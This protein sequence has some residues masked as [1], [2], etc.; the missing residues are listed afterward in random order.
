[1]TSTIEATLAILCGVAVFIMGNIV[2]ARNYKG[3]SNRLFFALCISVAFWGVADYIYFQADSYTVMLIATR[4]LLL[5]IFTLA[6]GLHF[7]LVFAEKT[8]LIRSRLMLLLVYGPPA[9]FTLINIPTSALSGFPIID[10]VSGNWTSDT[11][12]SF[13]Y[14]LYLFWALTVSISII[15]ISL[16]YYYA[17]KIPEQRRGAKYVVFGLSLSIIVSYI[18]ETVLPHLRFPFPPLSMEAFAVTCAIVGLGMWRSR[19]FALNTVTAAESILEAMSDTLLLVGSDKRINLVNGAAIR[20]LGYRPEELIGKPIETVLAS[21]TG[22]VHPTSMSD[23]SFQDLM[24]TVTSGD[25]ESSLFTAAGTCIPVSLSGAPIRD[26]ENSLHGFVCCARD[27]TERKKNEQQLQH[28]NDELEA[29]VR[30]RT[31]ELQ[32]ANEKL[33]V[34]IVE[35]EAADQLLAA[36]KERLAF[37][38]R[39]ISEGVVTTDTQGRIML[40]N[41]AAES[42]TG[43]TSREAAGKPV[44]EILR[45]HDER[46][47]TKSPDF[48]D[49]VIRQVVIVHSERC[50]MTPR[51]GPNVTIALGAA[52]IRGNDG[53]VHGMVMVM[54]D[55][56]EKIRQENEALK[57]RKLESIGAIA[58]GIAHDFNNTLTGIITNLFVAKMQ[59]DT[60]SETF[61]LI[62]E[63]EKAA[64]KASA[65]TRQLLTFS[66]EGE[67]IKMV[68]SIKAIIEDSIGFFLNDSSVG[69]KLSFDDDLAKVEIDRGQFDSVLQSLI[70]NA[71][72]AM[73]DGGNILIEVHNITVNP[74]SRLPLVPGAYVKISVQDEGRGIPQEFVERIFD[75]FFTT[76]E[77]K[78]GLGLS[79]AYAIIKK[80]N[81][82]IEVV[83]EENK[84]TNVSTYL[85]AYVEQITQNP[86]SVLPAA[87]ST[88]AK[89]ILL[90]DDEDLVRNAAQKLLTRMGF[91]VTC[92]ITGQEA[93]KEYQNAHAQG[94]NFDAVIL[95]LTIAGGMGGKLTIQELLK[96]DP[97]VKAIVSSGYVH[98]PVLTRY[99]DYG[100]QGM[101]AKPYTF[102]ELNRAIFA[103]VHPRQ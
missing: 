24:T 93:V 40:L 98:D 65:L 54:R 96:I 30:E 56:T 23:T 87:D 29:R 91:E 27:I 101:V 88:R 25:T 81:G 79:A 2:Y 82:H 53:T 94:I 92:C 78:T 38:L 73:P 52:P 70:T 49:M 103:V 21:E 76:K 10:P 102:E 31:I 85:P 43:W 72:D 9:F 71:E 39:S 60:G 45:I 4:L 62:T 7:V 74:A 80:H 12:K 1:M 67:P 44:A 42:L 46:D 100:F 15:V 68:A 55:I 36:E 20:L 83:S 47:P 33:K 35:R 41:G 6:I 34:E 97:H 95:D 37:T 5:R 13:F 16:R 61:E 58:G 17:L 48:K 84:G 75:P 66:S 50:L 59:L 8:A 86:A 26:A 89:R 90:M 63:A 19:L 28:A 11:P 14:Y 22:A 51:S 64:F 32:A 3:L 69:Y 99:R 77:S 18:T 57:I